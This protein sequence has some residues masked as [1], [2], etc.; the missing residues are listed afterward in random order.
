M[1]DHVEGGLFMKGIKPYYFLPLLL[2]PGIAA[3]YYF[4][5]GRCHSNASPVNPQHGATSTPSGEK[6]PAT[7]VADKNKVLED[8]IVEVTKKK[9][10]DDE[11][12]P[13]VT[14][15]QPE[16]INHKL[17]SGLLYYPIRALNDPSLKKPRKGQ[18]VTVH[19]T[20]WIE[21]DNEK[22]IFDSSE[23]R[24]VPFRFVVG[25]GQVI[26]G[27]DEGL[28]LMQKGEKFRL[29]IPPHLAYGDRGA[30]KTIPPAATLHFDVDLIDI[31]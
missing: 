31:A 25:I 8:E 7:L 6:G 14:M 15:M 18:M 20:G 2:L 11:M 19:Y 23:K 29:I 3:L 12:I 9:T 13:D 5:K 30:G 26:K 28:M 16:T 24:G 27:W 4:K 10:I 22:R 17:P 21:Q 1:L